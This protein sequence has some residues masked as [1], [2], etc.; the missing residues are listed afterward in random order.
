MYNHVFRKIEY[1]L[2]NYCTIDTRIEL[3]KEII[4][5]YEYNQNYTRYIKNKSSSLE[6]QVIRNIE[7]KR[8]ILQM[9]K[10]KKFIF[11]IL[12]EFESK[13]EL[14]YKFI[15]LKYFEKESVSKIQ[16]KLKLDIKEQKDI[17]R[18]I[19]QYI[20]SKLEQKNYILEEE[21]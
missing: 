6:N 18:E 9:K 20:F 3:L 5:N 12:K 14:R 17:Q 7:I 13:Y 1:Y 21:V 8:K 2:Y 4:N 19:L 10:W 16:D 15:Y 11:N